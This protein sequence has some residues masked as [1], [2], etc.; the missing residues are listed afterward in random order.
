MMSGTRTVQVYDAETNSWSVSPVQLPAPLFE[1]C[2][3]STTFG[4]VVIGDFEAGRPNAYILREGEWNHLPVSNYAHTNPGCSLVTINNHTGILVISGIW[5]EFLRL[6]D[7]EWIILPQPKIRRFSDL[8]PTVGTSLGRIVV[9][10]GVDRDTGEVSDVIEVWDEEAADW[11]L[12]GRVMDSRRTRQ[13]EI[14]VPV[15]Y[16]DSCDLLT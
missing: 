14:A 12:S 9:V 15:R 3:V 2:A 11:R 5:A 13:T 10:G 4:I 6:E 16:L 8:K 1:G 7:K